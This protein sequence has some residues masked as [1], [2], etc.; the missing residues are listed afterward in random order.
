MK[1]KNALFAEKS[2]FVTELAL[3]SVFLRCRYNVRDY[4]SELAP[5]E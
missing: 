3:V 2:E 4:D 5:D 1:T